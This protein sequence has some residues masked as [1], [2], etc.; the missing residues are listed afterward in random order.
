MV[1]DEPKKPKKDDDDEDDW[2]D[3]DDDWDD[4][5]DDQQFFVPCRIPHLRIYIKKGVGLANSPSPFF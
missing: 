4:D 3:D 5:D 1:F 2:D